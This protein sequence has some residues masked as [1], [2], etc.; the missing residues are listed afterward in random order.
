VNPSTISPG[1]FLFEMVTQGRV[2]H[3]DTKELVGPGEIFFHRPGEQ[4][5]FKS[6]TD[7]KYECMTALFHLEK[8]PENLPRSFCWQE[9][10]DAERFSREMLF[11]FH[12]EGIAL[13]VLGDIIW[14]QFS[15]RLAQDTLRH[16]QN[17]IPP[18]IASV[19]NEIAKHPEENHSVERLASKIGLSA[20]HLHAEFKSVLG[21]TPH[22]VVIQYRMSA[23]R[24]RLVTTTDPVKAIAFD[25]G[26]TNTENFCRAF[27]NHTGLTAANFRRKYMVYR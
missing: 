25:V 22:Q 21:K 11:A 15:F 9:T 17:T 16:R 2:M 19:V 6:P 18:R 10:R 26:Y 13:D 4:T 24:H 23:A 20:S 27:K 5:I 3:P 14:A 7:E 8:E 1:E 12:H